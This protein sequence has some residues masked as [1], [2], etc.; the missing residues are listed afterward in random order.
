MSGHGH[1]TPNADGSKARC[2]GPAICSACALE[3]AGQPV[4][5]QA[6]APTPCR[7]IEL[8]NEALKAENMMLD[9]ANWFSRVTNKYRKTVRIGTVLLEKKRGQ[10]PVT[11]I[12]EFCPF[13]GQRYQAAS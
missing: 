2:G 11:M 7:C 3:L 10:R 5:K 13:C 6:D 12:P 1:V 4:T 9:T 8:T